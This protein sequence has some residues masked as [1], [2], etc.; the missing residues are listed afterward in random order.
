VRQQLEE[1][2]VHLSDSA[3]HV[4]RELIEVRRSCRCC[5]RCSVSKGNHFAGW[6][7]VNPKGVQ[8]LITPPSNIPSFCLSNPSPGAVAQASGLGNR[9]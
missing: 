7:I 9:G 2:A 4:H 3:C 8:H 5:S 1:N 6:L